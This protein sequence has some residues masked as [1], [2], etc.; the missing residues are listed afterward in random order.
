MIE[1][2]Y[3]QLVALGKLREFNAVWARC[4]IPFLVPFTPYRAE[5]CG[6][7]WASMTFDSLEGPAALGMV[8]CRFG[9]FVS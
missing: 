4:L 7:G 2:L 6:C 1:R 9:D 8:L 3:S 5:R